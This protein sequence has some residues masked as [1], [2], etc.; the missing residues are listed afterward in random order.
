MS[1]P[2]RI[3]PAAR[4][5]AALAQDGAVAAVIDIGSNSVRLVIYRLDGRAPIPILNEKVMAGLGRDMPQT[6]RLSPAGVETALRALRRFAAIL[7]SQT[8]QSLQVVATAAVRAAEDG[9]A[10]AERV[11]RETGLTLRILSGEEEARLS[12]LGVLGAKPD[13][14]GVVGDLGGSSLELVEVAQGRPMPGESFAVGPLA[15]MREEP[16]D[17]LRAAAAIEAALADAKALHGQGGD[18]YAVGGA[19]RAIGR[20]DIAVKQHPLHILQHYEMTRAEALKIA[21]FV[22]KQSRRSLERLEEAAAKRADLLP[23]A[24]I[25]LEHILQRGKFERVILSSF[26]LREGLLFDAMPVAAVREHILVASAEAFAAPTAPVRAFVR[27]LG[28]WIAPVFVGEAAVFAPDRDPLL[29]EAAARMADLGGMLHPDQR[30]ELIFDLVVRAPLAGVSHRERAFLAASVHHRYTKRPP[31][32]HTI[33]YTALLSEEERRAAAT[34]GAAL[35][36]GCD[37]AGRTEDLLA[38]FALTRESG[39]LTL[40]T[41]AKDA[42]LV[43]EQAERRLDALG[44]LLGLS[45]RVAAEG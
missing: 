32:A 38:R 14:C 20:I 27:A 1:D 9:G 13:A 4:G 2:V 15:L 7:E 5:A 26:G 43:G 34:V 35:R 22:R 17:P 30:D 21:E 12:A 8:L 3:D 10:F 37:A 41:R 44:A 11:R 19:W 16:F 31:P 6:Q 18:F 45:V 40:S 39:A 29:R 23:Y 24:A 25:A 28:P 42:H 33:A 36:L